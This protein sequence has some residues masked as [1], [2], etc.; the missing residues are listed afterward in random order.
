MK[1]PKV[2]EPEPA[3][4][5]YS[6]YYNLVMT[7]ANS[8]KKSQV[9]LNQE[10]NKRPSDYLSSNSLPLSYRRLMP[11]AKAIKLGSCIPGL[12]SSRAQWSLAPNF[13]SRAIRKSY[14][15]HTNHVPGT[16]DFTVSEHWAPFNFL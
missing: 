8:K 2:N 9:F 4:S 11:G 15:F 16:L 5:F 10:S 3:F 1:I 12:C 13:C 14:F 6:M 7:Q